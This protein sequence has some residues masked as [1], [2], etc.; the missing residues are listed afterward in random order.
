MAN[1]LINK[2][3]S[4]Q[5]YNKLISNISNE[6]TNNQQIMN[7]DTGYLSQTWQCSSTHT[8]TWHRIASKASIYFE[9]TIKKNYNSKRT[10]IL[11]LTSLEDV[12]FVLFIAKMGGLAQGGHNS[13]GKRDCIYMSS[14]SGP[15]L[16]LTEP[17]LSLT[18]CNYQLESWLD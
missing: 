13:Q 2:L 3:L 8:I 15:N 10:S 11:V 7:I 14:E 17:D 5:D 16:C 12:I 9:W 1:K 18:E 6:S 4:Y